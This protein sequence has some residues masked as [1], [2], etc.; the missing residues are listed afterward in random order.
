MCFVL[1]TRNKRS[2]CNETALTRR[3]QQH[4]STKL[5]EL[6]IN[7]NSNHYQ[8]ICHALV[9]KKETVI[10]SSRTYSS[11]PDVN[12]TY[13][14]W[15]FI[16][17]TADKMSLNKPSTLFKRSGFY[18]IITNATN[19]FHELFEEVEQKYQINR[20]PKLGHAIIIWFVTRVKDFSR[21]QVR[22]T[23]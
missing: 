5:Y 1:F 16:T 14:S 10:T 21:N 11:S 23:Y 9:L 15:C 12:F 17:S 2:Q 20:V 6:Y 3:F 18:N 22:W 8:S 19:N 13:F 7:W 4:R